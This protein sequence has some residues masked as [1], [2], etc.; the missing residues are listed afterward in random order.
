[1]KFEARLATPNSLLLVLDANSRDIPESMNDS[2]TSCTPTCI[3]VGTL[4]AID[5]ETLVYLADENPQSIELAD[6]REVFTGPL[7]VPSK[8]VYVC[9]TQNETL[10]SL[11]VGRARVTV[12]IFANDET[13]PSRL[14]DA[15]DS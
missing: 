8:E 3:A 7:E 12:T 5:G 2:L 10:L 9:T 14:Y 15:V 6:L 4:S 13:E 11:P 1:M